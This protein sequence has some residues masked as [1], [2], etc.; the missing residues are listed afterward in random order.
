[1]TP[2]HGPLIAESPRQEVVFRDAIFLVTTGEI[3]WWF[4][5]NVF[6]HRPTYEKRFYIQ[7]DNVHGW[8]WLAPEHMNEGTP[9]IPL[10]YM[11]IAYS[12]AK[13]KGLVP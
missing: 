10:L 11:R 7:T 9:E 8:T 4:G 1:M 6:T 13:D 12:I 3:D 5:G 2:K